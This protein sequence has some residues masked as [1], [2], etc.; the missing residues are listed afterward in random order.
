MTECS[1]VIVES[2]ETAIIRRGRLTHEIWT[3]VIRTLL[4]QLALEAW[5][6]RLDGHSVAFFK[7]FN[8]VSNFDDNSTGFVATDH[9]S[10]QYGPSGT[11][12]VDQDMYVGATYA[13]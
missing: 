1:I 8:I 4:A 2:S 11:S 5:N 6:C 13:N 3:H 7:V 9:R 12:P 10:V